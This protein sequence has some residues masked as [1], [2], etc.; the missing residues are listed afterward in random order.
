MN[1]KTHKLIRKFAR[2]ER[3]PVD[4]PTTYR[5]AHSGQRTTWPTLRV[6]PDCYKGLIKRLKNDFNRFGKRAAHRAE[7]RRDLVFLITNHPSHQS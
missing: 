3:P 6:D 5:V 7:N 4:N 2:L 1:A